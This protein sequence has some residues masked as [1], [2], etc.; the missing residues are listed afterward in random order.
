MQIKNYV[1]KSLATLALTGILTINIGCSKLITKNSTYSTYKFQESIGADL[2]LLDLEA[3]DLFNKKKS[4]N[5]Y[6]FKFKDNREAEYN[7]LSGYLTIWDFK[8]GTPYIKCFTEII[9]EDD[10]G[11][12]DYIKI[13]NGERGI[14]TYKIRNLPG[15]NCVIEG[16]FKGKNEV[17]RVR[18]KIPDRIGINL[19]QKIFETFN[20]AIKYD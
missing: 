14:T 19:Y 9:D 18:K 5:R 16:P 1:N 17:A 15:P 2:S 4:N 10:D 7:K 11:Q 3:S 13:V 8:P 6:L 20:E 12:V